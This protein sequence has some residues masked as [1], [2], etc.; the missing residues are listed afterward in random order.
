[1]SPIANPTADANRLMLDAMKHQD[2]SKEFELMNVQ[3]Q[4][5]MTSEMAR[6]IEL[7]HQ[8]KTE[9]DGGPQDAV[10]IL[11]IRKAEQIENRYGVQSWQRGFYRAQTKLLYAHYIE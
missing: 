3:R 1:M 4:K 5:E 10:P 7:A 2:R 6:L 9:T 8:L 11:E